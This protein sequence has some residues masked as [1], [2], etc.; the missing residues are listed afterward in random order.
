MRCL[1]AG[2]VTVRE[3]EFI[4]ELSCRRCQVTS[5]S[6]PSE[7]L[8]VDPVTENEESVSEGEEL[9][10]VCRTPEARRPKR[11]SWLIPASS[12]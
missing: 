1:S 9:R 4:S 6:L 8:G 10:D 12:V 7:D 5:E 2:N 3:N 11:V